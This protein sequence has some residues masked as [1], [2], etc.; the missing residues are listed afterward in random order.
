MAADVAEPWPRRGSR[1]SPHD[2]RR[3]RRSARAPRVRRARHAAEHQRPSLDQPVQI[4][5]GADARPCAPALRAACIAIRAR[6]PVV[7]GGR[8]LD[9]RRLALDDVDLMAGALGERWPR[10]SPRPLRGRRQ[11]RRAAR[12]AGMP[13]A[14]APGRSSRAEA[15]PR[16]TGP[17]AG[18]GTRFTVSLDCTAAIAAPCSTAA[19][20]VREMSSPSRNGRAAS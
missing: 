12:R 9:V 19:S 5:A 13:A 14:S 1:R 8:D 20:I 15:S 4:V 3:R 10:R 18:R 6:R 16:C 11:S 17:S 2:R 7:R